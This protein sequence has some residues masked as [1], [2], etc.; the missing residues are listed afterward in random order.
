MLSKLGEKMIEWEERFVATVATATVVDVYGVVDAEGVGETSFP[1]GG[2]R[3]L[4]FK[5]AKWRL[6]DDTTLRPKKLQVRMPLQQKE[7]EVEIAW[8]MQKIKPH[9]VVHLRGRVAHYT[10]ARGGGHGANGAGDGGLC[11]RGA[12]GLCPGAYARD[13][14]SG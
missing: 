14:L 9:D 8:W 3:Y 5:L 7:R 2:P 4:G 12:S 1:G 10:K 13:D 6:S 11:G